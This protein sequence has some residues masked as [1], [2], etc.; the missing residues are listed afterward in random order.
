MS[1]YL[2]AENLKLKRTMTKKLVLIFPVFAL[3]FSFFLSGVYFQLNAFN[4]WYM[5]MLP[6]SVAVICALV[7]QKEEK[8]VKYR[9]VFSMP[10]DLKKV[11]ASKVILIAVY[12]LFSCVILALGVG[13]VGKYLLPR[14]I[15]SFALNSIVT[16]PGIN[17][18]TA[19]IVIAITSLW[20]IPL[21]LFLAKKFGFFVPII[22]NTAVG[23]GLNG[24]MAVKSIWWLC[25]YSWTSRLMCPI[26]GILPNGQLP[27]GKDAMLRPGVIPVGIV[28][29]ILL[30]VVL[31]TVT[32]SWFKNQEVV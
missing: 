18:I 32:S 27:V 26:L 17:A 22:L 20:Q 2:K 9:A 30:F 21:C 11:W 10:I 31:L 12:V 5:L 19:A 28:L 14:I 23:I 13:I 4:W 16:I 15:S 24:A 7:N 6:G 25:P 29:S 8:K 1:S 3:F